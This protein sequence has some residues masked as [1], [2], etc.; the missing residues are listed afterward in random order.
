MTLAACGGLCHCLLLGLVGLAAAAERPTTPQRLL[1]EALELARSLADGQGYGNWAKPLAMLRIA[2]TMRLAG[3]AQQAEA[4][5]EVCAAHNARLTE[6][7]IR[8]EIAIE[9]CRAFT[10][11]GS[12]SRAK[13]LAGDISF[14]NYS[15]VALYVIARTAL[16]S[17]RAAEAEQIIRKA[18][19]LSRSNPQKTSSNDDLWTRA[20]VR[21]AVQMN[22][23]SLARELIGSLRYEPWRSA[24]WGDLA[25][26][27]AQ[28]GEAKQA[29]EA[30]E[31]TPDPYMR[32]LA[33]A[34]VGACFASPSNSEHLARIM[35]LLGQAVAKIADDATHDHALRVATEKLVAAG[36]K[37]AATPLV[38]Q[39]NN[40]SLRL[41]AGL[42]LLESANTQV[43]T[44]QL[45]QCPE[46]DRALLAELLMAAAAARGASA[47]TLHVSKQIADPGQR[48][49][50]LAEAAC[51]AGPE[52]KADATCLLDAAAE[53]ARDIVDPAWRCHA[54]L[55][56]ALGHHHVKQVKAV[57]QY[58]TA[59]E[60][61]LKRQT[62]KEVIRALFS[63]LVEAAIACGCYEHAQRLIAGKMSPEGDHEL[64]NRLVP[65]LVSIGQYDLALA[66]CERKQLTDPFARRLLVY[67]LARAG[68]LDQAATFARRLGT[69]DRAEA[70]AEIA[71]A[72]LSRPGVIKRDQ[73]GVVGV[74]LHGSWGSWFPRLERMGLDW[75]LMPFS[76]PYEAGPERLKA[77]YLMLAYPGTGGHQLHVGVA[78]A[79]NMREYLYSGGGFFGICAGQFLATQRRFVECDWIYMRGQGPHQVQIRRRHPIAVDLPSVIVINRRNG[80]ILIP[81]PGCETIGWYDS[82]DRFAALV[83]GRYG[84]GRVVAFS[85]H[86]E[87]S[88]G[89]E[90]RDR[91]CIHATRW[92]IGGVP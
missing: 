73:R 51:R 23:L 29:I 58:L 38:A 80:G 47:T 60:E 32:T 24:A 87:G 40:P 78:G 69:S 11:L 62:E 27:L 5:F 31:Q 74:S 6:P 70:L 3:M 4:A 71:L 83:A 59:A 33:C 81:R 12:A 19:A 72:Q 88:S 10:L 35:Q 65:M 43:M 45:Q 2:S 85:P 54:Q 56:L 26:A 14:R 15:C 17:G 86:P 77:K 9:L 44:T 89:F 41:L 20:L 68:Q 46:V 16:E 34:R 37:G 25:V 48:C 64:R 84:W 22:E 67:R 90:P 63:P 66:Q 8:D 21:L 30:A 42:P 52:Q 36:N 13:K 49:R 55:R 82:I 7:A 79:E 92:A 57:G 28:Q 39:I 75:E 76:E 1:P 53:A 61:E 18:P 91:L 50:A